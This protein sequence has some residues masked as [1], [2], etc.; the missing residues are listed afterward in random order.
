MNKMRYSESFIF[1]FGFYSKLNPFFKKT[2]LIRRY[3]HSLAHYLHG[4]PN[5]E[6]VLFVVISQFPLHNQLYCRILRFHRQGILIVIRLLW[7]D[8]TLDSRFTAIFVGNGEGDRNPSDH[9]MNHGCACL[10]LDITCERH[11][12]CV[13]PSFF[14]LAWL[15]RTRGDVYHDDFGW[16]WATVLEFHRVRTGE[17]H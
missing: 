17:S 6:E 14:K 1:L 2:T 12:H 10:T 8:G 4:E 15:H 16:C 9:T 13:G 11:I 5:A 3:W 7:L